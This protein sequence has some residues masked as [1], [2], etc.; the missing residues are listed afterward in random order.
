MISRRGRTHTPCSWARLAA[1]LMLR[2]TGGGPFRQI[3]L[4]SD[5]P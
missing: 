1:C 2:G 3:G 5:K 4:A